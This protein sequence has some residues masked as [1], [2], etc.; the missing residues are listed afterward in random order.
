LAR[1][2]RRCPQHGGNWNLPDANAVYPPAVVARA[3]QYLEQA[4]AAA[5]TAELAVRQ[6]IGEEAE[7]W[8]LAEQTLS[9]LRAAKQPPRLRLNDREFAVE[10]AVITGKYVRDLGGIAQEEKI[11]L[12]TPAGEREVG[13]AEELQV[14]EGMEFRSVP[15]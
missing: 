10:Q 4:E 11:L 6:R 7:A 13:D 8:A 1:A 14:V 12:I 5:A 9:A 2:L 15:R 3:R